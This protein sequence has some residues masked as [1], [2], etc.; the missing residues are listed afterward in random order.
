MGFYPC[1]AL[2]VNTLCIQKWYISFHSRKNCFQDELYSLIIW[3]KTY[4][5]FNKVDI[6]EFS[7]KLIL[8]ISKG[9]H[10][11]QWTVCATFG[12]WQY[13]FELMINQEY[14]EGM[15]KLTSWCQKYFDRCIL[16]QISTWKYSPYLAEIPFSM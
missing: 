3:N 11:I 4:Y 8:S 2:I 9:L 13:T 7:S 14:V 5:V 1:L 6:F 16:K 15:K 10:K 12:K